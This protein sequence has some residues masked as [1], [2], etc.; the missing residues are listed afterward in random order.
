MF[1]L[2]SDYLLDK[3]QAVVGIAAMTAVDGWG[4]T[5]ALPKLTDQQK[6]I[7]YIHV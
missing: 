3:Y 6:V 2:K 4:P 1:P 7:K 5:P